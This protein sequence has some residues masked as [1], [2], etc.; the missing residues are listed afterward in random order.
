VESNL[1]EDMAT[2]KT[3]QNYI[4]L[5][6][7]SKCTCLLLCMKCGISVTPLWEVTYCFTAKD[8]YADGCF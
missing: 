3:K 6:L 5:V 2:E 7:S 1:V 4:F 8:F